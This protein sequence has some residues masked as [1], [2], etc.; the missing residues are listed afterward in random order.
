MR[1]VLLPVAC[2]FIV[3]L[4]A[5]SKKPLDHTVYDSW[6]AIGERLISNNGRYVAYT[7]NPQEGDG[8]LVISDAGGVHQRSIDRGYNAT[9]TEDSRYCI[10]KIK[11]LYKQTRDARIKKKRPDD[12][13]KDSLGIVDMAT[14]SLT[15]I[16]RVKTFNT[17]E[18]AAGW[19]AYQLEKPLGDTGRRNR[20]NAGTSLANARLSD[21]QLDSALK[22]IDSLRSVIGRL[23]EK[24]IQKY[25]V[26]TEQGK[27]DELHPKDE[28]ERL[29]VGVPLA[30]TQPTPQS[31]DAADKA[32]VKGAPTRDIST[33]ADEP[34][35][36]ASATDEGTELV[37]K[38]FQTNGQ[39]SYK[40]VSDYGFSKNGKKFWLKT[41]KRANDSLSKAAVLLIDLGNWKVDTIMR[42]LNDA[43]NFAMDETGSQLAFVAERDSSAKALRKMYK[44]W[45]YKLG[46]DSATI[47]A[48]LDTTN[49]PKGWAV[50]ENGTL[51]FSKSGKRLLFGTAP[52]SPIKDT[53]TPD[54]EKVNVDV[55]NYKDDYLQ[56]VQ[57]KGLDRSLKR[58]YDALYDF[59]SKKLLQLG[60]KKL[61]RVEASNEG[62]GEIFLGIDNRE[63]RISS[64][65]T[66]STLQDVYA[67]NPTTGTATLITKSLNGNASVSRSGK[68]IIWFD[69]KKHNYF[70][71]RNGVIKNI[72]T[73]IKTSLTDEENDVPDDPNP[74]GMATWLQDDEAI[75]IYDR[76]DIWKVSPDSSKVPFCITNGLGRSHKT[77]FRYQQ[78]NPDE[79]M[80]KK[81]QLLLL[82]AFNAVNKTSGIV[83]YN[84]SKTFALPQDKQLTYPIRIFNFKK[85]KNADVLIYST[86]TAVQSPDI[87]VLPGMSSEITSLADLTQA[88][89]TLYEPNPQQNN[90]NWM[91]AEL[92]NWKAYDGKMTQGILYKPEDFDPKKK[93]PLISYFYETLS[94][95]LYTYSAPAPTPSRLNIPFFVSRGY[96]VLAPDIHYKTG[97][98]GQDAYNYIVS[99]VRYVA[100]KGFIDTGRL[101][102][103]G[104][105]WGGYQTAILV[106]MT[107]LFK[108]AW[109]GA[110]VANMTSAYGGI[111]WE[112]GSNRQMQYEHGQSRLGASLW[113]KP[114][115]YIKNSPLFN[116][117][118][119]K[120]PLVI[121]SNDADGAVPWYQGI[122]MFTAMRRL[123]KPVWL[124]DYNGEAHNLVERKNRK[125]IQIREQQY[126]DW[127]LKGAPAPQWITEG[128]PAT[129]KGRNWGLEIVEAKAAE[130]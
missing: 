121:M 91:T 57:L 72:S 16:P 3:S 115:I 56:T 75:L 88:G 26:E 92:I 122:E 128:V 25:L 67:I 47:L 97:Q 127:Q 102:L 30:G 77:T 38:S 49:I 95:G 12:M 106:T 44:L 90:Y 118:K 111:R 86:E 85:A 73:G 112:S 15:K 89:I 108:A 70:T 48:G 83:W 8:R 81:D 2:L 64:Q 50:S 43:K 66:G 120:T 20:N 116:L 55:W 126:F 21:P 69:N 61:E 130:K 105:S 29:P 60:S 123:G 32:P 101:G 14:D 27:K 103:Q 9:L 104:Q 107:S 87:K 42:G 35:I 6:E 33:D 40:N 119:I 45:Y 5:Q 36:A 53:L 114:E 117:P 4:S 1:L 65:W 113:D 80:V 71:W 24:V 22:V 94:D 54:F 109:A 110:P 37:L 46:M 58:S 93:Y 41:T 63:Y 31:N 96:C 17:P 19:L 98:P 52:I 7:V 13:P 11:P 28:F 78:L 18:K 39:R 125:D 74:Y 99:G 82:T 51:N 34:S 59:D 76:Y 124:L 68:Y 10:F 129:E 79:R 62:D 84:P 23:P 100:S